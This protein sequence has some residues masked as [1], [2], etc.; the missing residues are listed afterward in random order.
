MRG[1]GNSKC[2][3]DESVLGHAKKEYMEEGQI[4]NN[5]A[6]E[7]QGRQAVKHSRLVGTISSRGLW[8]A[9]L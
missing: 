2:C 5:E 4:G 6:S 8:A 9:C 7:G 1:R 3:R